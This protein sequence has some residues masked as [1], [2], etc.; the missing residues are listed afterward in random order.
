M[1]VAGADKRLFSIDLHTGGI[2]NGVIPDGRDV[3]V[4]ARKE[5]K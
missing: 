3:I 2:I 5:V 1:L 4:E